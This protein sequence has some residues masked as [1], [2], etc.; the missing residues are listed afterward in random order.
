MKKLI[1]FA[2]LATLAFA[3]IAHAAD[4]TCDAQAAEKKLAGA[5]KTSFLKKCN[6]DHPAA[7]NPACE[8]KAAEKKLHGAA[9]T[10][11]MKKCVADGGPV[12][13]AAAPAVDAGAACAA[14]S[15]EKKLAGAAKTSFEKKCVAD[16]AAK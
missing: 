7:G 2:A 3:G 14:K 9:Q 11:F 8:A 1:S 4:A 10:S 15:A 6:A 16:A 12:A 13:E 5:A